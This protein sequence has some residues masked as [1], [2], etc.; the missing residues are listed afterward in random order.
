[1]KELKLRNGSRIAI[2]GGGPAGTF[3]AHFALKLARQKGLDVAVTIFDGK[4]FLQRGPPGCNMCAGVISETLLARLVEEGIRLPEERVQRR[5]DGYYLQSRDFG[6]LLTHP[7]GKRGAISTVYRGS[8]PRFWPKTTDISFDDFLLS[9]VKERG[10]RVIE[11]VVGNITLPSDASQ[12]VRLL[13][14]SPGSQTEFEADLVV[15][16][17]GLNTAVLKKVTALGFGYRPPR[18]L[19]TFQA[20]LRLGADHIQRHLGNNI[21]TFS[22]GLSRIRFAAFTPKREHITVSVIGRKDVNISDLREL[23]AHPSVRPLFP[24][25]EILSS[26]YCC[27]RPRIAITPARK[28]FTDR[29]VIVGDASCSRYYKNGIESAFVT[30]QLAAEAAFNSGISESA[31]ARDYFKKAKRTIIRDNFYGRL[32]FKVHDIASQHRLLAKTYWLVARSDRAD[33]STA[34]LAQQILWNMFT[35][36]I[37]YRTIFFQALDLRLQTRLT[38][39]TLGLVLERISSLLQA[40]ARTL[41]RRGETQEWKG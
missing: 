4:N 38:V 33:D 25:G 6:L 15:G 9:Y 41:M 7:Q 10:A 22:L 11:K 34:Q 30:A 27:C 14:G 1:M 23:L 40:A 36:N 28:P 13:Y 16:A 8:G 2:I 21:Y 20:E 3:F 26:Q 39:T 5:I 37:P 35:G 17:F 12:P 18:F 24:P 31:F 32:L 19:R 29:F